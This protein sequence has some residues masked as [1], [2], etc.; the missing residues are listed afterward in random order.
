MWRTELNFP[1]SIENGNE[2]TP[3]CAQNEWLCTESPPL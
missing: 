2:R 3:K 1:V